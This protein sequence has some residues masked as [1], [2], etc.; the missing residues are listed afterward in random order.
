MSPGHRAREIR[1]AAGISVVLDLVLGA[2][3]LAAGLLAGSVAMVADA[4][5]SLI[6]VASAGVVALVGTLA[7]LPPD[8]N[9]PYGH[10]KVEAVGAG[11]IGLILIATGA[12]L[13]VSGISSALDPPAGVPGVL[14]L[15]AAGFSVVVKEALFR[16]MRG[17]G[18]RLNS[19]PVKA[20]AWHHRTDAL[21]SVAAL[22]GVALA[23]TGLPVLDPLVGAVIA[24][25]II[26]MG[27]VFA[28]GALE[29]LVDAAPSPSQV[30][31]LREAAEEVPGIRG[32][33]DIRARRYGPYLHVDITVRVAPDLTVQEG[34]QM[35]RR[36]EEAMVSR[37]KQVREVKVQLHPCDDM[38][39]ESS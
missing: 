25:F 13:L 19:S 16:Y 2:G 6:D 14:A 34:H 12:G 18:A 1:W 10:G 28:W 9:H 7:S 15:W 36:V 33:E 21:S 30:E 31:T 20:Q 27:A 4:F 38:G 37:Q 22:V 26:R 39:D 23:R 24:L 3:K 11:L 5:H 8:R 32:V 35:M 29:E 17:L